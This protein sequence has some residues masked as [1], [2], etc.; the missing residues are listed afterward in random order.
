MCPHRD[1]IPVFY[2]KCKFN[3]FGAMTANFRNVD[4]HIPENLK[5]VHDRIAMMYEGESNI[6]VCE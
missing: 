3:L 4:E 6:L 1:S 2:L 5:H